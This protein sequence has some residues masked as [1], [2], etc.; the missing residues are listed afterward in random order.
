MFKKQQKW[1]AFFVALTFIWLMQVSTMPMAAAGASEQASVA[2]SAQGPDYYEAVGQKT[3][4]AKKKS[5]LPWILIGVGVLAVTA[6][7]LFVFVLNKYDIRGDWN[8][9]R[10]ANNL[11]YSFTVK[12]IG[13]K[14]SGTFDA[15]QSGT[16][17]H[18]TYTADGKDVSWIFDSGS[19][20]TGSFTDKD[21]MSG[22]YLK[23]DGVTTGTWTATRTAAAA[24]MPGNQTQKGELDKK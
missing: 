9:I 20:Y 3:G 1:I 23:Y 7:V 14:A 6:V 4:P 10:T 8:I 22:A 13:E 19:E 16:L 24:A 15:M 17:L 21:T 2:S 11:P 18:G 12:F 5:I